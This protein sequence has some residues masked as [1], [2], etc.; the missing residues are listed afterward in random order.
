MP[1][2]SG[3]WAGCPLRGHSSRAQS[4]E[5]KTEREV[6]GSM[7]VPPGAG[8]ASLLDLVFRRGSSEVEM[9]SITFHR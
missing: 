7:Y 5:N 9:A 6:T 8:P 3:L 2:L 4:T 1:K